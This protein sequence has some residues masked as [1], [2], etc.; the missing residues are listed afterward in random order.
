M[1]FQY[2]EQVTSFL[3]QP[4]VS[5]NSRL[6]GGAVKAL[7]LVAEPTALSLS[8][9]VIMGKVPI[10]A[11]IGSI[12]LATDDLGTTGELDIGFY[13]KSGG[14]FEAVDVD[15]IAADLDVN[16]AAVAMTERR[17]AIQ[18]I[19][20]LTEAAWE[21]ANLS[22]RPDYGE[23]YIALTAAEATTDTGTVAMIVEYTE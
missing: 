14:T 4:P 22:A 18:G 11:R 9:A 6:H 13:K 16:A 17:F 7:Y 5:V 8:D 15:A 3:A 23:L 10:D 20:T 12:R 2:S 19:D 21:L 1:A